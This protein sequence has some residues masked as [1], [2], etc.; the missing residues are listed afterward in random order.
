MA[1]IE[2]LAGARDTEL[3]ELADGTSFGSSVRLAPDVLS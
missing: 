2:A 1:E 3:V